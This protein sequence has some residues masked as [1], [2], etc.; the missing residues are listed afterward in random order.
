MHPKIKHRSTGELNAIGTAKLLML[1]DVTQQTASANSAAH[2]SHKASIF[3][4]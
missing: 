4:P 3:H 1:P 2:R